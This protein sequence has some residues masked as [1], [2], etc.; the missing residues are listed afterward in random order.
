MNFLNVYI[1]EF[2]A[3]QIKKEKM[4]TKFSALIPS[5]ISG[6]NEYDSK[7]QE[8]QYFWHSFFLLKP[9]FLVMQNALSSNYSIPALRT[10]IGKCI[11]A[12]GIRDQSQVSKMRRANA[13]YLLVQI[14]ESLWPRIRAG[15][16]GV[17]AINILCGL[18]EAEKFFDRLF[19]AILSQTD[20]E[21]ALVLLSILAATRDI[22]TNALTDFFT[23]NCKGITQYCSIASDLH[24]LLFSLLLQLDRPSGPFIQH[25]KSI[26]DPIFNSLIAN[27]I[28]RCSQLYLCCKPK[29]KGFFQRETSAPSVAKLGLYV[30]SDFQMPMYFLIFEPFVDAAVLCFYELSTT[31]DLA[32]SAL[33]SAAL[34][35]LSHV[36]TAPYTPHAGDRM[37]MLLLGFASLFDNTPSAVSLP[38]DYQQFR[39]CFNNRVAELRECT[40]GAMALDVISYLLQIKQNVE[41][42][43]GIIG[44][45]IYTILYTFTQYR[46]NNNVRWK[47]LFERIFGYCRKTIGLNSQFNGFSF[48]IVAICSS[49][50]AALFKKDDGYINLIQ[51]ISKEPAIS[52]CNY[53]IPDSLNSSA[54]FLKKCRTHVQKLTE[55]VG[56]ELGDMPD[57]QVESTL[58]NIK[59]EEVP[60]DT[61]PQIEKFS[62]CPDYT[63]LFHIFS[64]QHCENI[65]AF[66]QYAVS[67]I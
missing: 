26:K 33:T 30:P 35:L 6:N 45:I 66:L 20:S 37:R 24:L 56:P 57:S 44:R 51:A 8:S 9:E 58:P 46:G 40:I 62:E 60:H 21:P 11:D 54:D 65:Q 16:F 2:F 64:R 32:N 52:A 59:I 27:L 42:I 50:R 31:P 29:A 48:L 4:Q 10:L 43:A 5:I 55:S 7:P 13:S 25:F 34:C 19:G 47:P 38:F 61:F 18:D 28:A 22:E 3:A 67:H 1:I 63:Q 14:F 17:V 12:I 49:F 36:V 41:P 39:S 23:Q 15:T 53:E